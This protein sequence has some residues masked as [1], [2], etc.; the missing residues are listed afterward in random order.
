GV[1]HVGDVTGQE[2]GRRPCCAMVDGAREVNVGYP[3]TGETRP[4]E[5]HGAVAVS[6][7]TVRL[8]RRLI[9]K[10]SEKIRR[11]RSARDNR[12]PKKPFAVETGRAVLSHR[13]IESGYALVAERLSCARRVARTFRS[14]THSAILVP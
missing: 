10:F 1:L 11:R 4:R 13:V 2:H 14:H 7:R 5:V 12:G 9:V 8:D 3:Y 6:A